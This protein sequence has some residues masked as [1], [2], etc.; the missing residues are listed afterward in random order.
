[1]EVQYGQV[2]AGET[3]G[4]MRKSARHC[5][6][7]RRALSVASGIWAFRKDHPLC[8]QC[9]RQEVEKY[10]RKHM[11]DYRDRTLYPVKWNER[12][13][14]LYQHVRQAGLIE[15]MSQTLRKAA[16]DALIVNPES[17][18]RDITRQMFYASKRGALDTA[19]ALA[20]A[21]KNSQFTQ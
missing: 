18:L 6:C 1:M 13:E 12:W 2:E 17:V 5:A 4:E 9:F 16:G 15:D 10:W 19:A 20:Q 7:G 21:Q 8:S 3:S 14:K 11:S